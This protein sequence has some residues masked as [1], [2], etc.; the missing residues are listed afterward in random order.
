M[1][2]CFRG[3]PVCVLRFMQVCVSV[4]VRVRAYLFVC[5]CVLL[6]YERMQKSP[7]LFLQSMCFVFSTPPSCVYLKGFYHFPIYALHLIV[8]TASF[9]S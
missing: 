6:L 7:S 4:Y 1:I 8:N 2:V 9:L 5:P 3:C